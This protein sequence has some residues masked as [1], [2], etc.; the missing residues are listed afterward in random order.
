MTMAA[1]ARRNAALREIDRHR[2]SLARRLRQA[3][4]EEEA[5]ALAHAGGAAAG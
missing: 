4:A 1:E 5:D 3:V 2:V